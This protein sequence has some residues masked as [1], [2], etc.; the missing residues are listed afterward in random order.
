MHDGVTCELKVKPTRVVALEQA[1]NYLG[2]PVQYES[3][4]Q[5]QLSLLCILDMSAKDLPPGILANN[6]ALL[7]PQLHG[8]PNPTS[9]SWV[10]VVIVPGN[11][12]VPS[13]WSGTTVPTAEPRQQPESDST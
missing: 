1:R 5:R 8:A 13:S 11:L 7:E 6:I 2:Q 4:T 10:G 9:P 3:G 12:P